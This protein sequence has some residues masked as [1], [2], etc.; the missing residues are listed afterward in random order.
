MNKSE[1][2]KAVA[3]NEA[4]T[5][6][7]LYRD[8][9]SWT[10]VD[11]ATQLQLIKALF[12]KLQ[13]KN[14][15][16]VLHKTLHLIKVLC[17]TGQEGF[18]KELQL[19]KYTSVV[20]DFTTYRGPLD[21]K[22]GDSWNERVRCEARAALEAVFQTRVT[23]S[24]GLAATVSGSGNGDGYGD[25]SGTG[26]SA[27]DS[28]TTQGPWGST[29]GSGGSEPVMPSFPALNS[30][31]CTNGA[32][33]APAAPSQHIG[34]IPS[35]N[36]WAQQQQRGVAALGSASPV[37]G[38]NAGKPSK[39]LLQQLASTAKSGVDL[40][41]QFEILKGKQERLYGDQFGQ[42]ARATTRP[43][44]TGGLLGGRGRDGSDVGSYEPVGFHLPVGGTENSAEQIM[45]TTTGPPV[46]PATTCWSSTSLSQP[47]LP[48]QPP[49]S[50]IS[51]T[52]FV[53]A[54]PS[55]TPDLASPTDAAEEL[56]HSLARMKQTPSRVELS[57]LLHVVEESAAAAAAAPTQTRAASLRDYGTQLAASFVVH[58]ARNKPWQERLNALASLEAVLRGASGLLHDGVVD[59]FTHQPYP[60][61]AN[62][63]VV[64][65]SLKERAGRVAQ[66]LNIS[67]LPTAASLAPSASSAGN[68][69]SVCVPQQSA[70]PESV[71]Q[72]SQLE[73]LLSGGASS[74]S[75]S[76]F[77][78][79]SMGL[80]MSM[81]LDT[82]NDI[83]GG[84]G[85]DTFEGMTIRS[86]GGCG[87]SHSVRRGD[88][89][90]GAL[91]PLVKVKAAALGGD[92][93]SRPQRRTNKAV[94]NVDVLFAG[95]NVST[96]LLPGGGWGDD[97]SGAT[98]V[99]RSTAPTTAAAT[100]ATG[101]QQ[102]RSSVREGNTLDSLL[103]LSP[104]A[105]P[106]PSTVPPPALAAAETTLDD[107]FGG[108]PTTTAALPRSD[109]D[110]TLSKKKGTPDFTADDLFGTAPTSTS[111]QATS[112]AQ[113]A[114]IQELMQYLETHY[115]PAAMKELETLI[116]CRQQE[117]QY[118]A[119]QQS[120][121]E[122]A[123]LGTS[124]SAQQHRHFQ[125]G[126]TRSGPVS[127]YQ[128]ANNAF[129][130]VQEEMKRKMDL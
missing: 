18:Q 120:C 33:P 124:G 44:T 93:A 77:P 121:A 60:V 37:F 125:M 34:E 53:S 92:A 78:I 102:Q 20:K 31:S 15:A 128:Q 84:E 94:A 85:G 96:P 24:T 117:L 4:P 86:A 16:F 9:A 23:G 104:T 32:P 39:T 89:Q 72:Q 126:G 56:V 38:S 106:P 47:P 90:P 122:G 66:L 45:T 98:R 30:C 8:I 97:D 113:L 69:S 46:A 19:S 95:G 64:Q 6:G 71:P 2:K 26:S 21:I 65:A 3:D 28:K 61:Q 82:D 52:T 112:A 91:S 79:S 43:G 55:P 25:W 88:A 54:Y 103:G 57:R 17:E 7:Y 12:D 105:A 99:L 118:M 35:E 58:L 68:G 130:D 63:S 29:S 129:A 111:P 22:Y 100:P 83:S 50:H 27:V 41:T 62:Y 119:V 81:V 123:E 101:G 13:M 70:V 116:L 107:L 48:A 74:P 73:H 67:P 11:Y 40:I 5:P 14:S 109:V 127:E 108:Q 51:T 59:F 115:D 80:Q 76:S 49:A 87:S 110:S 10:F 75:P 114:R 42:A 36:R 1:F